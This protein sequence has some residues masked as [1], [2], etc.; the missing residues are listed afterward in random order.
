M[1]VLESG[2]FLYSEKN[3][4]QHAQWITTAEISPDAENCY[5]RAIRTF[6]LA[7]IPSSVELR[8]AS[9]G[10]YRLELNGRLV[11]LGPAR[12]T[13]K[14][15]YVDTL[16]AVKWL[17]PG[18]NQISVLLRYTTKADYFCNAM[19]PALWLELGD[20]LV[21]DTSWKLYLC[22]KEWPGTAPWYSQQAGYCEWHD[23]R[24]SNDGTPVATQLLP[25]ESP[26]CQKQLKYHETPLPEE[27]IY[28][29]ADIP[30]AY[31]VPSANWATRDIAEL[32]TNE[33]HI[34]VPAT[35]AHQLYS[36]TLGGRH[37]IQLEPPPDNGGIAII[38]DF[39]REISGRIEIELDAP[40]GCV[41][42]LGYEEEL[43][44]GDRLRTDHSHTNPTYHFNDRL[45]LREGQNLVT[46]SLVDRGFRL[47]QLTLRDFRTP[48][49]LRKVH[50]VNRRYPLGSRS[51]FFCGDYRLNRLWE[52]CK[53]T[54]SACV[55][56]IYTDCPWRERLFY[57]N[58][59]VVENRTMLTGFGDYRLTKHALEITFDEMGSDD[60]ITSSCPGK[61]N[62]KFSVI[63]SANLT[64]PLVLQDYWLYSGDDATVRKYYPK[65][66]R[67]MARFRSWIT[68]DGLLVPPSDYW[69]F[70]DWSYEQNGTLFTGKPS[71][72]LNCLYLFACRVM[73]ELAPAAGEN[74]MVSAERGTLLKKTLEAFW[75][76]EYD[77][78][79]DGT[80]C[81]GS[82]ELLRELGIPNARHRQVPVSRLPHA[83]A[84]L[85]GASD[86]ADKNFTKP[87]LD[88][89]L[90]TPDFYYLFFLLE[91]MAQSGHYQQLMQT[92][93]RY[94][95]PVM[96]SGTPTIW[97]NGIH[98]PGKT[99]FGGSASLC[100][101]FSTAPAGILQRIV[102]GITPA[103]PGFSQF[104]FDP[105]IPAV[106]FAKGRIPTPHGAILVQWQTQK[107]SIHASL[108][109]PAGCQA[110]TP[111]GIFAQ[112]HHEFTIR[113]LE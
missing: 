2:F 21:S 43:W 99:G 93:E 8:I 9:E 57:I 63:L 112:G 38:F 51:H 1:P 87:M 20:M 100:H 106:G 27:H 101:G 74:S 6:S 80:D 97:E 13:H 59:L 30:V 41:A 64:L 69:N 77:C 110:I 4:M 14:I 53:E 40:A 62:S 54:L 39:A 84:I 111:T 85:A 36:L 35:I 60:L 83:L 34:P 104:R 90:L 102:L 94:W 44:H 105:K 108:T 19:S 89:K 48:V 26:V 47:V 58:D 50:A 37:C 71:S 78:L 109:V 33:P 107:S 42:D 95:Y 25:K 23:L 16:N 22:D 65:L 103:A 10:W 32:N 31:F 67:I 5:F 12:G 70:F 79:L 92:L 46:T 88:E 98:D 45:I 61:R 28:P 82:A 56:D 7:Q 81:N 29:A 96:D 24:H 68:P 15:S 91:A 11:C 76:P 66:K 75:S 3:K 52:L 73:D 49:V 72:L 86:G 17:Q 113:N 18:E 55:T